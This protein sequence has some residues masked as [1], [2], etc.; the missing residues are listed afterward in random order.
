ML[1]PPK[2]LKLLHKM[3][4]TKRKNLGIEPSERKNPEEARN[5]PPT[6][7]FIGPNQQLQ[8]F[9]GCPHFRVPGNFRVQTVPVHNHSVPVH[10]FQHRHTIILYRYTIPQKPKPKSEAPI[11]P[12]PTHFPPRRL[13]HQSECD[14]PGNWISPIYK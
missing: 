7:T 1:R 6:R 12:R 10:N 11:M 4:N 14:T 5:R 9:P 8:K 2:I 3:K 13:P